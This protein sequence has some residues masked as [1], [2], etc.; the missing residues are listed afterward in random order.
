MNDYLQMLLVS[1][2]ILLITF[3]V[4]GLVL[5][6]MEPWLRIICIIV[7][8]GCP[9]GKCIYDVIYNSNSVC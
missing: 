2:L 6:T 7:Y 9:I 4:G 3:L 5:S 8:P 1:A